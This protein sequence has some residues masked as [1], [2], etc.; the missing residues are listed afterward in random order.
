MRPRFASVVLDIDSTVSGIEGI[1]WLA[2]LRD[3]E[4]AG[5]IADL[6]TRAMNGELS[7]GEVYA[8]RLELVRPSRS[9][10]ERLAKAY[11]ANIASGAHE[12]IRR[13]TA[14][15]VRIVLVTGGLREAVLPL[16]HQL[17]VSPD[18]VHAVPLEFDGAGDYLHFDPD[19]LTAAE[20][21]KRLVV[22]R[23][24]LPRPVL[25]V[26][27]GV[28]DAELA[29]VVDAFAAYV[30]FVRRAPVVARADHVLE[31]F[32]ELEQAVIPSASG[33]G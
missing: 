3:P 27:D 17:G 9:E 21:G 30:G 7:L 16:A 8:A 25:A 19:A 26:G 11:I 2:G 22:E 6:T 10:I 23:L 13:L 31:S 5:K 18:D 12:T 20:Q 24:E 15:G 33:A 4:I 28:T 32:A 14:A 1:D 29:P